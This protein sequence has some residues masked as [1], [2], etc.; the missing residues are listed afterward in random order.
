MKK[1]INH[2]AIALLMMIA[3]AIQPKPE[4]VEHQQ[5]LTTGYYYDG[6][7][8]RDDGHIWDYDGY[9][10]EPN[11][12]VWVKFDDNGTPEEITDDYIICMVFDYT[13]GAN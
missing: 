1:S 7:V 10:V 5:Y 13:K 2:E 4:P 6:Y 3:V 8:I 11:S 9:L 12:P